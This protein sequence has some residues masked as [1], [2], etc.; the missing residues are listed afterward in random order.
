MVCGRCT[1]LQFVARHVS[2]PSFLTPPLWL[3]P[4]LG[5]TM[6]MVEVVPVK[7]R[8]CLG[9]KEKEKK[10]SDLLIGLV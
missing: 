5:Q 9:K 10:K 8:W 1:V 4:L 3:Q 7:Q 2:A 6:Q